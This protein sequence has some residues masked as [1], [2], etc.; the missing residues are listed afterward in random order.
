MA[1]QSLSVDPQ[2]SVED[3]PRE[4]TLSRSEGAE[5]LDIAQQAA[6]TYGD[7]LT[8]EFYD[9]AW[10]HSRLLPAG[11]RGFLDDFRRF[12]PSA[13]CLVHGIPV[14]DDQLGATPAHW[15]DAIAGETARRQEIILALCGMVLGEPCGWATLQEGCI[16]QNV[17]PIKGDEIRQSGYGSESLLEFHT[18]DGFHP[19]RC[20]YLMLLGLRNS[21]Q[22]PT[23]V[24]SVRDTRLTERDRRILA[25]DRYY[26]FPDTEH[27][28]QLSSHDENHPA[29]EQLRRKLA[30]PTPTSVLFGDSVSPYMRIDRPFMSCVDNDQEAAA[31]LD[32]FMVELTRVQQDVVVGPGSLLI[33]DNYLAAHGRRPFRARY[34]G[35]D[36]WLKKLTVSR[37]LRRHLAGGN[38]GRHRVLV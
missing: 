23:I 2:D 36:R 33:M 13:A 27:I 16:V 6:D 8:D 31:A 25:E 38:S 28:R 3:R 5:L 7:P 11:L 1:T 12:E 15:R 29:L 17:L 18:E 4:Y 21:D 26:I 19:N 34:D 9:Q 20:D 30:N 14:D 24:A 32:R 10:P 37:N 22:V 35:T